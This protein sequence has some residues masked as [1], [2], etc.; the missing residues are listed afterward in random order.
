MFGL[1]IIRLTSREQYQVLFKTSDGESILTGEPRRAKQDAIRDAAAL[2]QGVL[3]DGRYIVGRDS[4]GRFYF[5]FLGDSGELLGISTSFS[6]PECLGRA[7]AAL[8]SEAPQAA[9]I[10]HT[11]KS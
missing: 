2:R 10:D 1:I 9:L 7:I 3:E 5:H 4:E 8:K 6:T 11:N